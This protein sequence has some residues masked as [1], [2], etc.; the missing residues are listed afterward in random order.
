V[1]RFHDGGRYLSINA[2][3][4]NVERST[5]ILLSCVMVGCWWC[6]AEDR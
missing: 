2:R 3:T 4:I 6:G 5:L 1:V